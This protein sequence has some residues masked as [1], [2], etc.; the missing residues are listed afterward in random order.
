[1]LLPRPDEQTHARDAAFRA[2]AAGLLAFAAISAFSFQLSVFNPVA[3]AFG[4]NP[5]LLA[6]HC[7]ESDHVSCP[8]EWSRRCS[9]RGPLHQTSFGECPHFLFPLPQEGVLAG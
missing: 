5:F 9:R 2:V 7:I 3:F 4:K 8:T 1:M 6:E